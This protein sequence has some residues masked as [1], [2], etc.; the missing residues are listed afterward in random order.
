MS[1]KK[2]EIGQKVMFRQNG[3]FGNMNKYMYATYM[4]E[5]EKQYTVIDATTHIVRIWINGLYFDTPIDCLELIPEP[6]PKFANIKVGDWVEGESENRGIVH[7][8]VSDV[9]SDAFAIG[10][11][12]DGYVY[13][14]DFNGNC[15]TM[16]KG[17]KPIRILS[18]KEVV[19]DFG[20]GIKGTIEKASDYAYFLVW[21]SKNDCDYSMIKLA[22]L[23]HKTRAKVESIIKAQ[24]ES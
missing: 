15:V 13:W 1:N 12:C 14:Y 2:F 5:P 9:S 18:H 19:V 22:A 20:S 23:D 21:H 3:E 11:K 7:R 17:F 8:E 4:L 16:L 24:E 10:T 6:Q